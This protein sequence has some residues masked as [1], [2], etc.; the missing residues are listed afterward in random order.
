MSWLAGINHVRRLA[1]IAVLLSA[2]AACSNAVT[3]TTPRPVNR[4]VVAPAS[5]TLFAGAAKILDAVAL[6]WNDRALRDREISWE[7]EA[8]T[9]AR[10]STTGVVTAVSPGSTR[11]FATSEGRRAQSVI[12]VLPMPVAWIDVGATEL[13]LDVGATAMVVARPRDAADAELPGRTVAWTASNVSVATVDQSGRVVGHRT[14]QSVITA[15]SEGKSADV[16]VTVRAGQ[17]ATITLAPD[18]LNMETSDTAV[19]TAT[20]RDAN[21]QVV[22]GLAVQ[23]STS[24]AAVA[25]VSGSGVVSALA[26]GSALITATSGGRSAILSVTVDAPPGADLLYQRAVPGQNELFTLGFGRGATPLRIPAGTVSRRPSASPSGQE[27]V[28]IAPALDA[29]GTGTGDIFAITRTGAN[30]RRLSSM[31]GVD[32]APAWS[33]STRPGYIAFA[34]TD[35]ASGRTDIWVMRTDGSAPRN[36]TADMPADA[37]RGDP[38]WSRDGEWI[39]FSQS[40]YRPGAVSGS[41]WALRADG[42]GKLQLTQNPVD[43]FDLHPSWSPDGRFIAFVRDGLSILTV[44]TGQVRSIA[45]D[46]WVLSPTWSPDGRHIAF[47]FRRG[48]IFGANFDLYTIRPYGVDLRLRRRDMTDALANSVGATWIAR[49]P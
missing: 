16:R 2:F 1:P 45:L 47:S 13:T 43:G 42:S 3:D 29:G 32:D 8:I 34:H 48:G 28:F 17:V 18:T 37:I 11:I 39:A 44:A 31:P 10:V 30:L 36:L 27:L 33:P 21:G 24:N 23:W 20:P 15:T 5:V 6:D 49:Q 9:I 41:L 22:D 12:T 35:D 19:V 40:S 38:A 26:P 4:V 46:G 25:T 14:G 7:S